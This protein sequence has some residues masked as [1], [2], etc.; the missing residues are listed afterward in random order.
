MSAVYVVKGDDPVLRGEVLA[1]VLDELLAHADRAL[2]LEEFTI[3]QRTGVGGAATGPSAAGD[4]DANGAVGAASRASVVS[5]AINAAQSPP[6]MT[7]LRVVVVREIGNLTVADAEPF[8][9]YLAD[10]L[11]TTALVFVAGGGRLP[12]NLTKAWKPVA[13]ER[14]PASEKTADV[15]VDHARLASIGI[16]AQARTL[17]VEHLGE[18][19]GR[20]PQL[21]EVL[22]STYGEGGHLGVAE[23]SPYLG[24]TGSIPVYQLNNAIDA[25]DVPG[26]LEVLLRLLHTS[27]QGKPMHPL[28]V[29]GL[30]HHHYRR[31]LVLDDPAIRTEA[32]AVS[33]LGGKVKPYPARKALEQSRSLGTRKLSEAFDALAQADLDLKG[34]T[35]LPEDAVIEVLVTRL[36]TLSSRARRSGAGSPRGARR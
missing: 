30:L 7:A 8:V 20:V 6:F 34:A 31:L 21:V 36:A 10:P 13:L 16:D 29:L 25:G 3:P 27:S 35:A 1:S 12:A 18:D 11:A 17:I 19:S 24:A 2:A 4:A 9:R 28:Q 5:D 33:A 15:L 32:D 22:R 23:V 14:G 26:A